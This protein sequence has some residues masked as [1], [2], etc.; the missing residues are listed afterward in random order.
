M[1]LSVTSIDRLVFSTDYPFQHPTRE[2]IAAFI[3]HFDSDVERH[4]SSSA[5][6]AS[7]Y[8]LEGAGN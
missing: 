5:N 4:A 2:D 8:G 6:A 1:S 3:D 7:L